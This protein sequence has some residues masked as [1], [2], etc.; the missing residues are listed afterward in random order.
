LTLGSYS[1]RLR[2]KLGPSKRLLNVNENLS[3]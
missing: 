2:D 1:R 3:S